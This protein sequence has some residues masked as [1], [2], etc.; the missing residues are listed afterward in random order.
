MTQ[1]QAYEA[2]VTFVE[3]AFCNLRRE[4]LV[5][6]GKGGQLNSARGV[7]NE[8]VP[9]WLNEVPLKNWVKGFSHASRNHGGE[10]ALYVIIRRKK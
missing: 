9:K 3:T 7:L 5:I 1:A 2:I 6:T 8:V 4:V 10:G